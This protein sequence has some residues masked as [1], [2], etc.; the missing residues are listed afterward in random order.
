MENGGE[1]PNAATPAQLK[2]LEGIDG[3]ECPMCGGKA[4]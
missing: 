1:D 3:L 4:Q 2:F